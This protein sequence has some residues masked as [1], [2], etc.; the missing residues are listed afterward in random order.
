[1]LS[2]SAGRLKS[3][4]PAMTRHHFIIGAQKKTVLGP[5]SCTRVRNS[6]SF[7]YGSSLDTEHELTSRVVHELLEL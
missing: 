7:S 1:M 3:L 4:T 6:D 2:L 5:I